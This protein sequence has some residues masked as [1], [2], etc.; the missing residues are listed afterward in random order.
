MAI[1]SASIFVVAITLAA[2][3][4]YTLKSRSG[5]SFSEFSEAPGAMIALYL[6]VFVGVVQAFRRIPLLQAMAPQQTELQFVIA[7]LVVLAL[8]ILLTISAARRF[9]SDPRAHA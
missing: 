7:Q 4:K 6:N 1:V 2:Q 5:I 3:D 8:F 9:R